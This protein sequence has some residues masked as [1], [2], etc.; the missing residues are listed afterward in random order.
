MKNK[1]LIV[2]GDPNSVNSE[3]IYKS[4]KKSSPGIKNKIYV[5]TN[6]RLFKK[7]LLKLK[8]P[9]K[10]LKVQNHKDHQKTKKLKIVDIPIKFDNPFKIKKKFAISFISK[11]LNYAHT[12]ALKNDVKGIINCAINK[13]LLKNQ[14]TPKNLHFCEV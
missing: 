11:S 10:I 1:I 14:L 8:Y 7:Q 3:I 5:I 6:Y 2:G 4:W 9:L 12:A 13:S